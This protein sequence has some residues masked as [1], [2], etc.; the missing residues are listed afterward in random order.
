MRDEPEPLS[1]LYAG[2]C[3]FDG[4]PGAATHGIG[5]MRLCEQHANAVRPPPFEHAELPP[6]DAGVL[7]DAAIQ[8]TDLH[9]ADLAEGFAAA[10]HIHLWV[11][12]ASSTRGWR[13]LPLQ[14]QRCGECDALRVLAGTEIFPL[15]RRS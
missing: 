8:P 4:C 10:D 6:I 12:L 2:V 3:D 13:G 11:E 5:R 1:P 9:A 14:L 7:F 15:E